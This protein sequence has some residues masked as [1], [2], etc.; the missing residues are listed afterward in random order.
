MIWLGLDMWCGRAEGIEFAKAMGLLAAGHAA[1]L[2]GLWLV[3]KSEEARK[4][5]NRVWFPLHALANAYV[6]AKA[7]PDLTAM[8]L[9][10]LS[11]LTS[12][13]G[14]MGSSH[15]MVMAVHIY[16]AAAF[17]LTGEDLIHHGVSVGI[18]GSMSYFIRWGRVCNGMNMFVC[19]LPGGLDYVLL[20]G[21]KWG[22]IE[23]MTEK[24]LNMWL[25][26][27][28][29]WPGIFLMLHSSVASKIKLGD[30]SSVGW[31]P[32]ATVF[33]LHGFNGIY[34]AQKVTGNTHI[35]A[36]RLSEAKKAATAEKAA[37]VQ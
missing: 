23:K 19:G 11:A 22:W 36:M 7:A 13:A 5:A 27:A 16:H 2:A 25:Q 17:A 32:I 20:T 30:A 35:S 14:G 4:D 3:G 24:R 34:Y 6:V 8:L 29:R 26:T 15:G 10:P 31:I 37:K 33:A 12:G 28:I 18:A 1:I 9:D 21:V